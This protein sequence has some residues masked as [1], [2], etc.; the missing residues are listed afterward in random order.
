MKFFQNKDLN[1]IYEAVNSL[2]FSVFKTNYFQPYFYLDPNIVDRNLNK[3][4][5]GKVNNFHSVGL[6]APNMPLYLVAQKTSEYSGRRPIV[7]ILNILF[8]DNTPNDLNYKPIILSGKASYQNKIYSTDN[9]FLIAHIGI[10]Q[11]SI[12]KLEIT[13]D[14]S[15]Y[16]YFELFF[17]Q[18][19]Q[20]LTPIGKGEIIGN[21]NLYQLNISY[22]LKIDN[23]FI[24]SASASASALASKNQ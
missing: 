14:G 15:I 9:T 11:I 22:D 2:Q 13:A 5:S 10:D 3:I 24:A 4:N 7:N 23:N 17:T 6:V 1:N 8:I 20:T 19:L 18:D 12:P 16:E 21:P